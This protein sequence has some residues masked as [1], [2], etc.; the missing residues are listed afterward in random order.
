VIHLRQIDD[1]D[2]ATACKFDRAFERHHA[3][4]VRLATT[5]LGDLATAEDIVQETFVKL[6]HA[7]ILGHDNQE[8]A[9]WLRRVC[10]NASLNQLRADR[11]RR[12]RDGRLSTLT[13]VPEH[14]RPESQ[15]LRREERER[16][17]AA[18]NAIP[19]TLRACLVLRHSGYSY[20]E[21]AAA[22]EIAMGSVGVYLARGERA[23]RMQFEE[24][25]S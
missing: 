11:R 23:F 13:E 25:I 9:A 8:I 20:A 14:E 2:S 5:V 21:I 17:R 1:P 6:N 10:V 19:D 15:I 24:N 12:D 4:L 7:S 18:L 16:V 22:L 3:E